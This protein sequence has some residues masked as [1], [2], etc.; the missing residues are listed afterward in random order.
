MNLKSY[1]TYQYLFQING[2]YVT[3]SEKLFLFS[4]AILV[5]LAVVFKISAKLAPTP[6]DS[7]YRERFYRL[8]LTVGLA[9]LFWYMCRYESIKFFG[10]HF[11]IWLIILTGLVWLAAILV[12]MLRNYRTKKRVWQKEQV[13]LKYLPK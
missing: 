7:K 10:S 2:A 11:V 8:L 1:F 13:K 3:P 12:S 4:G 5:L 6:V 9:E